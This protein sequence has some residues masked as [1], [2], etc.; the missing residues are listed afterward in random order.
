MRLLSSFSSTHRIGESGAENLCVLPG[1]DCKD[2][3]ASP[4][5]I[6]V[7]VFPLCVVYWCL[8]KVSWTSG[9]VV[10]GPLSKRK[11]DHNAAWF[12]DVS[13]GNQ[14]TCV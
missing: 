10:D 13:L 3:V 1:V 2:A 11:D 12:N 7:P 4:Y 6:V 5:I 9:G 8:S 14:S